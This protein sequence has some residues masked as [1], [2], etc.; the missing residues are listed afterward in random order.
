MGAPI[1]VRR[2]LDIAVFQPVIE[3]VLDA[4][5]G[6][7]DLVVEVRQVMFQ[8]PLASESPRFSMAVTRVSITDS[9]GRSRHSLTK[10]DRMT[11]HP[12]GDSNSVVRARK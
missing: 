3:L 12:L 10:C 4:Q 11:R 1:V 9:D 5:V 6:K 8:R 7:V 2:H